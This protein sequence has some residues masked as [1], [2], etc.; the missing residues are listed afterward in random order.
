MKMVAAAD[1]R[2]DRDKCS[3]GDAYETN[4][5]NG[6]GETGDLKQPWF[7]ETAELHI[8]KDCLV[9]TWKKNP[10]WDRKSKNCTQPLTNQVCGFLSTKYIQMPNGTAPV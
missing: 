4:K 9:K 6:E 10:V 8:D 7:S 5:Q 3:W 1:K 2:W